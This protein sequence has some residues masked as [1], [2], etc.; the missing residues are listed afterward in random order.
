MDGRVAVQL[1]RRNQELAVKGL[2]VG[3]GHPGAR[4]LGAAE[5]CWRF[6]GGKRYAPG[7]AGTRLFPEAK[8][9]LRRG[10]CASVGLGVDHAR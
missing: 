7:T 6:L 8:G 2:G 3:M 9:A 1:F 5:V 10:A 4:Y